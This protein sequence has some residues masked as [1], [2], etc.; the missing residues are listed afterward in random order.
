M[1][2]CG[3]DQKTRRGS[4]QMP[5]DWNSSEFVFLKRQLQSG[6]VILFTGAGFS[7]DAKNRA[8]EPLPLGGKLSEI[9][10]GM[11]GFP[12]AGEVLPVVYEAVRG[13][14]G[15]S[16]M[17]EELRKQYDVQSY[18][19]WYQIVRAVT[20]YRLYS[21]NIDNLLE[22][23]YSGRGGQELRT[24]INPAP[25][26]ERDN[27]FGELQGVHLHGHIDAM[28]KGLSFT[29]PDFGKLTA[30]A[31]PWYRQFIEDLYFR[32]VLF[33]GTQL[34]EPMFLALPFLSF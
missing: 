4:G 11:A 23:L 12:Y 13:H 9:L 3:G 16:K 30:I 28:D 18:A 2:D 21:L 33:I 27:L 19:D 7:V 1:L 26:E 20:W 17:W 25:Y 5:I 32:S 29:F 8:G 34:E 14:I 31:D 24:I 10:A 6:R 15:I 22:R